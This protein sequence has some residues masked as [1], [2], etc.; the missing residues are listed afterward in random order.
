M[1]P[2]RALTIGLHEQINDDFR[3]V[4][5][6]RTRTKLAPALVAKQYVAPRHRF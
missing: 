2:A 1:V 6:R 3:N 4:F 5:Y